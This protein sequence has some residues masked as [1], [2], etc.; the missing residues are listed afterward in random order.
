M[1]KGWLLALGVCAC[2]PPESEPAH[3]APS[4]QASAEPTPLT[5]WAGTGDARADGGLPP[6]MRP[7]R[8]LPVDTPVVRLTR[9]APQAEDASA[10]P[11]P[12]EKAKES[13]PVLHVEYTWLP[14]DPLALVRGAE[15]NVAFAEVARARMTQRWV[16]DFGAERLRVVLQGPSLLP[17][18]TELRARA[19]RVGNVALHL[20]SSSYRPLPP[21]AMRNFLGEGRFDV[22]P[23]LPAETQE[24][25]EGQRLGFKVRR[26][27]VQTSAGMVTMEL[28]R[29]TDDVSLTSARPFEIGPMFCRLLSD[30][31]QAPADALRCANEELPLYAD[32]RW[33]SN[34]GGMVLDAKAWPK[35]GESTHTLLAAPPKEFHY[36]ERVWQSFASRVFLSDG[37]Q[38]QLRHGAERGIEPLPQPRGEPLPEGLLLQNWRSQPLWLA[39]DGIPVA[40]VGPMGSV[41]L[42]GLQRGR[43]QA[44]WFSALDDVREAP[45]PIVVPGRSE[46]GLPPAK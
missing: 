1:R 13:L 33:G 30:F 44:Q 17:E 28:A 26:V 3:T 8:P 14:N 34:R 46:V 20:P 31:V 22:A 9:T 12:T 32:V 7:D 10:P 23:L 43:Y 19:D 42:R 5:V 2:D 27:S 11:A 25:G 18:G 4:P 6:V 29:L 21:G 38:A 15:S 40:W 16:V 24:L 37:E 45:E 39:L 41:L 36:Q 35:R